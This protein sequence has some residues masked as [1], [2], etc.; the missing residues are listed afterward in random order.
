LSPARRT[1]GQATHRPMKTPG[2]NR[3]A[4]AERHRPGVVWLRQWRREIRP[5]VLQRAAKELRRLR[6]SSDLLDVVLE[7]LHIADGVEQ[8]LGQPLS[9]LATR[10]YP[11]AIALAVLLRHS[12]REDDVEYVLR[13]LRAAPDA[14]Q[15]KLRR[16]RT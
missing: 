16:Q 9:M 13:R 4:N 8:I 15:P 11:Q 14:P 1:V 5:I 2:R 7:E 6:W 10:Q 3:T 12:W